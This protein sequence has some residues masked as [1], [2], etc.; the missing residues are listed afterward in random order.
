VPKIQSKLLGALAVLVSLIVIGTG[1]AAEWRLR[2]REHTRLKAS[3]AQRA[4][5][6]I[7]LLGERPL[8]AP[9]PELAE[10]AL[11]T[12]TLTAARVTLIAPDG[13]VV[14]DSDVVPGGL[15]RV[16]NH[17]D[18]PEVRGALAGATATDVRMSHTVGRKLFYLAV[19]HPFGGVVRLAVDLRDV[20]AAVSELRRG[21]ALAGGIALL[22]ALALS[23]VVSG[24]LIRPLT[25]LR[26]TVEAI[27]GGN[28]DARLRRHA[29]DELGDI[30]VALDRMREQ[31]RGQL[32]ELRHDK[33]Q[34]QAVL[35]GMVEGVL[36]IGPDG[37]IALA[38]PRLRSLFGLRHEVEGRLPIEVIRNAEVQDLL[39]QALASR[40]PVRRE[41][42]FGGPEPRA[43]SVHA[44]ALAGGARGA[45]AVFHDMS[46][47]RRL[48][49]VRRDFV[50]NAS[51]ELKTPLTAIRGF[52]ETLLSAE[53]PPSEARSY[54]EVIVGHSDRLAELLDDLLELSRIE[55]R[56]VK[57]ELE[58]LEIGPIAADV[59]RNL[60][61]RFRE[62][63]LESRLVER[64][65]G[66]AL[67]DY[68]AVEQILE[69]LLD[70]A[71]KYTEPGGSVEVTM[72]AAGGF[73]R[74]AVADTGIGI[75]D[76]DRT[77]IFERFYRVD[78]A[79]SR[80]LGGTGLGLS[81]AKHLV[82]SMGGE[83]SVESTLGAGSTFT[84]TLPRV[85]C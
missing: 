56:A 4:S 80:A 49:A 75:P 8:A 5:V 60:E 23:F 52:A 57:L 62:R 7:D 30:A 32:D 12:A 55:S 70:N 21:L 54:L 1:Y 67:A 40:E 64:D 73:V 33:E 85:R 39:R 34:L 84:F 45:V 63:S 48:D 13:R 19:P 28:L 66:T 27:A 36:V 71:A 47:V 74:V 78:K 68:R 9:D 18:R 82:Q 35:H 38:N 6:V 29:R 72:E 43:F 14:A 53:L 37:R 22:G 81:I 16:E 46:E 61:P 31:L 79:R 26:Q 76:A 41:I 44:V 42:E 24:I 11:R 51:H 20:D 83:I 69:N 15:E 17:G 59:L 25:R 65:P 77:R 58:E 2:E 3:V 50:A 10:V